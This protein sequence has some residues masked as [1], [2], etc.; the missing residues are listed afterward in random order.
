MP[1]V[2]AANRAPS[3][4]ARVSGPAVRTFLNIADRWELSQADRLALLACDDQRFEEWSNIARSH[5]A[6]VLETAVLMR[7]SAILGLFTELRQFLATGEQE[8]DWLT[9]KHKAWPCNG[10]APLD[11]LRGTL[12]DQLDIRRYAS[13]VALGQTAP[14]EI[15]RNV[16]PYKDEN[17]VWAGERP[18]IRAI[19]FDGFGTLVDIAGKRRPFKSLL[20]DDAAPDA[21][22]RTLTRPTSL[23][24][25][26]RDMSFAPDEE[27]LSAIEAWLEAELASTR[28][29]RGMDVLWEALRR[30]GLRVG[31]CSNLASPYE[32]ALLGCLPRVPDALVLSFRVGLMKPQ[33]EIYQLVCAQLR[34]D[35]EQVLFVGDRLEEDV[36]G[37]QRAGLLAMHIDELET[38]LA[39]GPAPATPRAIVEL[40]ERLAAFPRE[41]HGL[42]PH[43]PEEA[44]DFGLA[45]VT[46][47]TRMQYNRGQLLHAL[48]SPSAV[49]EGDDTA[50][51]HLLCAFVDEADEALLIRI[52]EGREVG[53]AELTKAAQA[54]LR[55][56]DPKLAWI[57]A[58]DMMSCLARR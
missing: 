36:L 49:M 28:L 8:R 51:K 26:A 15:D 5:G 11:L 21:V 10:R 23:R 50:L 14:N 24:D 31:V 9:D 46:V 38:A 55:P 42:P 32:N 7:L 4:R 56:G 44:L 40:V 33:A 18:E 34:L 3:E 2:I 43:S 53:W 47:S 52:A 12:D 22:L 45:Q 35:P 39:Q 27:S 16:T 1:F 17:L 37:P 19:C 13:G 29:R 30:I 25:L 57:A 20:G 58:R 41:P 48:R 54:A 6:L